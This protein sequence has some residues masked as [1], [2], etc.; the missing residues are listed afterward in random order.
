MSRYFFN[1]R[2]DAGTFLDRDGL[3]LPDLA[4]SR[5]ECR[6]IVQAVLGEAEFQDRLLPAYRIEIVDEA[7][8]TVLV[9]PFHEL[10]ENDDRPRPRA[11]YLS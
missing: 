7:G 8:E 5:E 11:D 6:R 4:A 9:V 3:E 2:H 10:T 1:I